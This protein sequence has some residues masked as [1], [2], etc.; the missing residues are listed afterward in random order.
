[1]KGVTSFLLV[2]TVLCMSLPVLALVADLI[3][4]SGD[5][6]EFG[7]SA[8]EGRQARLFG[9]SLLVAATSTVLS[10]VWG[11]STAIV[12]ARRRGRL[13]QA[14]EALSYLPLVI[15]NVVLVIGWMH[16]LGPGGYVTRCLDWLSGA[17]TPSSTLSTP[18]GVG[19]VLSLCYFPYVTLT[20]A[21][22]LRSISEPA[23]RSAELYAGL[24]RRLRRIWLPFMAPYLAT[25]V[26]LVFLQSFADFG[27][28][29][30]LMVNVY[31]VEIFAQLNSFHDVRGALKLCLAPLVLAVTLCALRYLCVRRA[32]F[33][34]HLRPPGSSSC[35]RAVLAVALFTL[36]ASSVLPLARLAIRAG[37]PAVYVRAMKIAGAQILA[38]L[39]VACWGTVLLLSF[40]VVF[41]ALY[42]YAGRLARA[43]A[44]VGL[45]SLL[46]FPGAV[47]GLGVL[48]L[49]QAGLF[50]GFRDH[51]ILLAYASG[52][53]YFVFPALILAF[54]ARALRP[55]LLEAAAI[56]GAG[57]GR[58]I[59]KIVLPVVF[60]ALLAASALSFVLTMAEVS[61]AVLVYPPGGM[62][63]PVRL[64]S[65]LHFGEEPVVAALCVMVSGFIV[66][67][68]VLCRLVTNRPLLV[69]LPSGR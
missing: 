38:S 36:L 61:A 41:A 9:R 23:L 51:A 67:V 46:G 48:S 20:C 17:S 33:S 55:R 35:P 25:G 27:V 32:P 13:G 58:T 57:P 1:M 22:G 15:P 37:W 59:L 28:P 14:V 47:I 16:I 45:V 60:P 21:Q 43:T 49:R 30:A 66:G 5:G 10:V 11:L 42:R 39:E 19:F 56:H 69:R 40:A 29:S 64:V 12:I 2:T 53:R 50:E 4:E 44:E 3:A 34:T 7:A 52:C 24:S 8:L 31:P 26:V 63:L 6:A 68:L 54:A 65:L 62:T 18:W